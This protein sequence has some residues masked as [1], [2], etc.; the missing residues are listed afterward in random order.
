MLDWLFGWLEDAVS[1]LWSV[2]AAV[3]IAIWD[4]LYELGI[5]I[6]SGVLSGVAGLVGLI[7]VPQFLTSGLQG[8][9]AGLD[10]SVLWGVGLLGIPE[11]LAMLGAAVGVRLVRKFVTLFQW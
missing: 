6:L 11:G 3:F 10:G 1:W 4:L 5:A 2:V 7:P 9:F 8:V